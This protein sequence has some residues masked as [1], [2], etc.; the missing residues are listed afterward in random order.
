MFNCISYLQGLHASLKATKDTYKF[1]TVSGIA[2]L[3]GV[4]MNC[5]K[6]NRFFAVD[7]SEDGQTYQGNSGGFFERRTYTAFILIKTPWGDETKRAAAL[8]EARTIYHSLVTKMIKDHAA[9]ANELTTL[10]T[11]NIRF[12]EV[13]PAFASGFS[14]IYFTFVVENPIN[15]VYDAGSWS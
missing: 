7:D 4:V 1:T 2:A 8:T 13:P 14:G 10:D 15:L 9:L 6:N 12:H 11:S 3:E 5:K